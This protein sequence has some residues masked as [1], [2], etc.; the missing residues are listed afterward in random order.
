MI[1]TVLGKAQIRR[2]VTHGKGCV[3]LPGLKE[4]WSE[5]A[6]LLAFLFSPYSRSAGPEGPEEESRAGERRAIGPGGP[7]E[8]GGLH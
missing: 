5:I 7:M 1:A 4:E 6:L 3:G 8:A 2:V